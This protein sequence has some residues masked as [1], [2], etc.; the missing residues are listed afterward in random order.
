M[1]KKLLTKVLGDPKAK[2]LKSYDKIVDK[3]CR[4]K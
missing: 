1:V 4:V 2:Q 3:S